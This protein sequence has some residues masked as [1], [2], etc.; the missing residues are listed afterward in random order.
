MVHRVYKK[1]EG[2]E[3]ER[4]DN[5]GLDWGLRGIYVVSSMNVK[6][7]REYRVVI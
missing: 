7:G 6:S 1:G 4:R 2:E 3:V 5:R